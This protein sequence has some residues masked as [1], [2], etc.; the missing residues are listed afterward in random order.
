MPYSQ[1]IIVLFNETF[2][3]VGG[4]K[5]GKAVGV[6]WHEGISG[7]GKRL[8]VSLSLDLSEDA[9]GTTIWLDNCSRKYWWLYTALVHEVNKR[10]GNFESI[11]L[12]HFEPEHTCMSADAF[13]HMIEQ[14]MRK[15]SRIETF[16]DFVDLVEKKGK[17]LVMK[18]DDF[19]RI[20]HGVSQASYARAKPKL[21]NVRVSYF[22]RGSYMLHWRTKHDQIKRHKADFLMRNVGKMMQVGNDFVSRKAPRGVNTAKVENIIKVLCPHMELVKRKFWLELPKKG[23]L[24]DQQI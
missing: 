11:T 14:G 2:A 12:K 7:R 21:E 9:G 10:F 20:P 4:L 3:P 5:N 13:H 6:L 8:L 19:L 22:Q 18:Y 17:A 24:P 16:Y 15:N 23:D 1:K